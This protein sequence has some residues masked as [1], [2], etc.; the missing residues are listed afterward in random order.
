LQWYDEREP[1]LGVAFTEE[2]ARALRLIRQAPDRWPR[3][4]T[5][6]RRIL[7]RRFPYW[8]VYLP[9]DTRIWIVAVAHTSRRPRYWCA[10][11][12]LSR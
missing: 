10:R 2:I 9:T 11:Q 12:V 3:Y 1:E 8:V 4:G 6:H 7:V 5:R